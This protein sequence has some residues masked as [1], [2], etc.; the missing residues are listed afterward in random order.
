MNAAE[1]WYRLLLA[2]YP[3][4]FREQRGGE[5]WGVLLAAT[6]EKQTRPT[7]GDAVN[8][9]AHGLRMRRRTGVT[10]HE[11]ALPSPSS[12]PL[13]QSYGQALRTI[14]WTGFRPTVDDWSWRGLPRWLRAVLATLMII[15][16]CAAGNTAYRH[17]FDYAPL[18]RGEPVDHEYASVHVG[19][20][21]W[22]SLDLWTHPSDAIGNTF[23]VRNL[24][25]HIT[26]NG[27]RA[28]VTLEQC[29]GPYLRDGQASL[30]APQLCD[31]LQPYSTGRQSMQADL[32]QRPLDL[33]VA[34]TPRDAGTIVISGV[35]VDARHGARRGRQ[36]VGM[37]WT[38]TTR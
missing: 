15:G 35:T 7:F 6:P 9:V 20:T 2:S 3:K 31:S 11:L 38:V 33:V 19:Q 13:P 4:D 16:A 5:L 30:A 32:L 14:W 36:H 17:Y 24:R 12:A 18:Y 23:T 1:R 21:I 8:L 37:A 22:L 28:T 26:V 34:V 10:T 29:V 27:A 25:P